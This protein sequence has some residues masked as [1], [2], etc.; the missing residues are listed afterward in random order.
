MNTPCFADVVIEPMLEFIQELR[1][2]DA[3]Q[4]AT[5]DLRQ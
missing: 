3:P 4:S 5:E 1:V 2:A